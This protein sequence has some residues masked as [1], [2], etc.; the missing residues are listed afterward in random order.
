MSGRKQILSLYLEGIP[1]L[2]DRSYSLWVS[3]NQNQTEKEKC[4]VG[5]G[6]G[7]VACICVGGGKG[8][9]SRESTED[10]NYW[11]MAQAKA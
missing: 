6:S 8:L 11:K 1:T 2:H 5:E 10:R 9:G 3:L 7:E 4:V